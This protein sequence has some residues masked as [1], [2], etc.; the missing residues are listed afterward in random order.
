MRTGRFGAVAL[1]ALGAQ[2]ASASA[3]PAAS[4]GRVSAQRLQPPPRTFTV[5]AG[6]DIL[7]EG[8]VNTTAAALAPPGVRYDYAPLFEPIRDIVSWADLAI[9]HMEVPIGAPGEKAGFRGPG[10]YGSNLVA[11]PYEMAFDLA[12]VGFNRCSTASNHS[13]DL[14]LTGID[15]T[16]DALDAAGISHTGTARTAA[17]AVPQVFDVNGVKVAH[18]SVARNSNTGWPRDE[19]RLRRAATTANTLVDI[20]TARAAGAEVVI[21]SLH[22]FVELQRAPV[23]DDR[24]F[25]AAITA[26]GGANLVLVTGPHVVQPVEVVNGALVYWSL[27][28][29]ISGMGRADRGK[30]ADPRTLDELLATVR[31]T[32]QPGGGFAAEPWTVLLCKHP[33]TH[34][35]SPALTTALDPSLSADVR[36][37]LEA[38]TDRSSSVVADL[39]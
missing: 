31:F 32:E 23:A 28:N 12:R 2:F 20:A 26:P 15:T 6:G 1:L 33:T 10:A 14:G 4:V 11:A 29:F 5:A 30:Y 3:D 22:V 27:G 38:C 8:I 36:G 18:I 25:V 24:A 21:V 16:L 9:C 17:E 39:R 19:W 34:V 35:V 7:P 13:Y 37:H